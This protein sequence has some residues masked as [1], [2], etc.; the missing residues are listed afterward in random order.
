[1]RTKQRILVKPFR[2]RRHPA[3]D[4]QP[5]RLQFA[6][7]RLYGADGRF[8][9][10]SRCSAWKSMYTGYRKLSIDSPRTLYLE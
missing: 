9:W 10:M 7:S 5:N 6:G 3:R 4:Y 2:T 1:M 8:L